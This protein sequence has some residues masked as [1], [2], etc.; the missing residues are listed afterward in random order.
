MSSQVLGDELQER[1]RNEGYC[2]SNCGNEL[3]EGAH[4]YC[5]LCGEE[6][7]NYSEAAFVTRYGYTP[8]EAEDDCKERH[9]GALREPEGPLPTPRMHCPVCRRLR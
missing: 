6:N 4:H 3:L 7:P 1:Y 8:K 5:E 9:K 2:C